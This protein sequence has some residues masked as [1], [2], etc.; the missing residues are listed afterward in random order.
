MYST[1]IW[2]FFHVVEFPAVLLNTSTGEIESEFHAY[3][4][5]QEHPIL[6]E[7]CMELTG[8]KQVCPL[9]FPLLILP[10]AFCTEPI[11]SLHLLPSYRI[12]AEHRNVKHINRFHLFILPAFC[13]YFNSCPHL[14]YSPDLS[15]VIVYLSLHSHSAVVLRLGTVILCSYSSLYLVPPSLEPGTMP[16]M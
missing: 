6:S 10:S 2:W 13:S 14:V 8:I 12:L 5:P 11:S 4:Q 3:V 9:F 16:D 7:F 1:V 15:F